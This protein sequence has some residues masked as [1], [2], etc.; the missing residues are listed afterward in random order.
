M[1]KIILLFP[2]FIFLV[3]CGVS[4]SKEP[5]VRGESGFSRVCGSEDIQKVERLGEPPV[6]DL[7]SIPPG[8]YRVVNT[9][10]AVQWEYKSAIK[11]YRFSLEQRRSG[12]VQKEVCYS[13]YDKSDSFRVD[14]KVV[15]LYNHLLDLGA[16][17][18][19]YSLATNDM[20]LLN[21]KMNFKMGSSGA[22]ASGNFSSGLSEKYS[23]WMVYDLGNGRYEI[24][25]E[26]TSTAS[27]RQVHL[28]MVQ[29]LDRK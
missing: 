7:D 8:E 20:W 25:A 16:V 11:M 12:I 6:L 23:N 1:H 10:M 15:D 17:K 3:S 4:S 5:A 9:D 29:T 28:V 26:V 14:F 18:R 2:I 19:E 27:D 24:R 22:L 21:G 13:T